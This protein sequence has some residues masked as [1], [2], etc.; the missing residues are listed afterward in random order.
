MADCLSRGAYPAQK[1]WMDTSMHGDAKKT[2]EA[3][4]I[5]KAERLLEQG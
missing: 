1:E 4:H 5:I 3:K 2:A